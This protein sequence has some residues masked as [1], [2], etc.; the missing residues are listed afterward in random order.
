LGVAALTAAAVLLKKDSSKEGT[1][2]STFSQSRPVDGARIDAT[3][4]EDVPPRT[5]SSS[6][7]AHGLG[8][9]LKI[10]A[11]NK[12]VSV[13][14][15]TFTPQGTARNE[16]G[17]TIKRIVGDPTF[18]SETAPG[19]WRGTV[20]LSVFMEDHGRPSYFTTPAEVE[21]R[22]NADRSIAHASIRTHSSTS[23]SD[24][25]VA[26]TRVEGNTFEVSRIL[27]EELSLS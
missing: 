13:S 12:A 1:S 23:G 18:L 25:S 21:V 15:L 8:V 11:S 22:V 7:S 24:G 2:R 3:A 6:G 19:E 27:V 4:N 16:D 9:E 5:L 26:V 14:S 10:V 17:I 20:L